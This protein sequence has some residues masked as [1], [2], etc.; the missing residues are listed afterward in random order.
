M[1]DEH[2]PKPDQNPAQQDA[3]AND[4]AALQHAMLSLDDTIDFLEQRAAM[5][6]TELQTLR[7]QSDQQA[8]QAKKRAQGKLKADFLSAMGTLQDEVAHAAGL[9]ADKSHPSLQSLAEGVAMIQKSA[10]QAAGVDSFEA[11]NTQAESEAKDPQAAPHAETQAPSKKPK[12]RGNIGA[13]LSAAQSSFNPFANTGKVKQ[14]VEDVMALAE[15]HKENKNITTRTEKLE[16]LMQDIAELTNQYDKAKQVQQSDVAKA[17]QYGAEKLAK[18]FI[19]VADNIDRALQAAENRGEDLSSEND[20][21]RLYQGVKEA[22]QSLIKA[23][24]Q[25]N[26]K[27]EDPLGEKMDPHSHQAVQ[28]VAQDGADK[29]TVVNVM[30]PGYRL[31]DR[32]IR[33]A[34]VVVAQ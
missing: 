12:R 28:A 1:S 33:P 34:M 22:R 9:P 31:H 18:Q 29:D 19:E 10:L 17:A 3:P 27:R 32:I 14:R 13:M 5:M 25:N 2:A 23:F 8:T 30:A 11:Q 6:K 20:F 15:P 26:I 16:S 4:E 7:K 24:A 21:S